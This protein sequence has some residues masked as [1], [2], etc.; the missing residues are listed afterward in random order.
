[1]FGLFKSKNPYVQPARAVFVRAVERSRDPV[2][3]TEYGVPD[4][5]EGRFDLLVLHLFF[6]IHGHQHEE[7]RLFG[8][9]LFDAAFKELAQDLRQRG[10]GD[11]GIPKRM[12]RMMIAFNGRVHAYAQAVREGKIEEALKRNLYGTVE[13]PPAAMVSRMADYALEN[14]HAAAMQD[15]R[16]LENGEFSFVLPPAKL[17]YGT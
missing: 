12:R 4:S 7:G 11:M 15:F 13:N 2:F 5:I 14:I 9:A 8:Q 1:M 10:I 17:E 3:Y 6:I 16:Q